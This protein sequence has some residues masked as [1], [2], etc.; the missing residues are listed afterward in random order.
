MRCRHPPRPSRRRRVHTASHSPDPHGMM[1]H[2]L[3][4]QLAHFPILH[5][6][7]RSA[8]AR[9]CCRPAPAAQRH[10]IEGKRRSR[11][12]AGRSGHRTPVLGLVEYLLKTSSKWRSW[13]LL[14][15]SIR[16]SEYR[17]SQF[18][19]YCAGYSTRSGLPE[20]PGQPGDALPDTASGPAARAL[21]PAPTVGHAGA[22]RSR[23]RA[24]CRC[25]VACG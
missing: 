1:G 21:H 25:S 20:V 3:V 8:G 4:G 5:L 7:S 13:R 2:G 17:I 24:R 14:R 12:R 6:L 22:K 23:R 10:C 9:A 19:F 16:L 15:K 11:A 18:R